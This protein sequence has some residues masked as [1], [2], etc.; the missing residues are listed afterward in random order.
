MSPLSK[1]TRRRFSG[2]WGNLVWAAIFAIVVTQWGRV[3]SLWGRPFAAV[4]FA[5]TFGVM[6]AVATAAHYWSH[7]RT[8]A[9]NLG[10]SAAPA[11][12]SDTPYADACDRASNELTEAL[13]LERETRARS[14]SDTVSIEAARERT[15]RAALRMKE[16]I[17]DVSN[18]YSRASTND[19]LA[20]LAFG[21]VEAALA[22]RTGGT[23]DAEITPIKFRERQVEEVRMLIRQ[24]RAELTPE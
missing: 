12:S 14:G 11:V 16:L 18:A 6:F 17:V 1:A 22:T 10:T 9:A 21:A 13:R 19:A 7:R 20:R 8:T 4:V 2:A 15:D 23:A 24:Y 3:E 5:C